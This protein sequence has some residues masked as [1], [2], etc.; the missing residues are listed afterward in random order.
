MIAPLVVRQVKPLHCDDQIP[1]EQT[2][3]PANNSSRNI[4]LLDE[5][6]APDDTNDTKCPREYPTDES[7]DSSHLSVLSLSSWYYYYTLLIKVSQ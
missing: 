4:A 5:V 2:Q 3:S 7:E 1:A 6:D